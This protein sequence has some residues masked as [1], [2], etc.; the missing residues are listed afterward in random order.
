MP[1]YRMESLRA[2]WRAGIVGFRLSV[3]SGSQML[4]SGPLFEPRSYCRGY[5]LQEEKARADAE[6]LAAQDRSTSLSPRS[7]ARYR[8]RFTSFHQ[9]T[10]CA[11]MRPLTDSVESLQLIIWLDPK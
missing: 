4:N 7:S 1:S 10:Q 2:F 9:M 11:S 3:I 8:G 5:I 6:V